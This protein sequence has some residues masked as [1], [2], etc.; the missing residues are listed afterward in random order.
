MNAIDTNVFVYA[1]D[2]TEPAKQSKAG[3]FFRSV[4]TSTESTLIPW[5]VA[6]E[7]LARF[8]NQVGVSVQAW[9]FL[10]SKGCVWIAQNLAQKLLRRAACRPVG[11]VPARYASSSRSNSAASTTNVANS[12]NNPRPIAISHR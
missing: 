6:V 11:S 3:E 4:F 1:F 12:Q 9:A 10:C 7:L 8:R 2:A 5:Q